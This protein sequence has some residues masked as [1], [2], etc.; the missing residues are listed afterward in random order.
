[1][2]CVMEP[3]RCTGDQHG[4]LQPARPSRLPPRFVLVNPPACVP[5]KAPALHVPFLR[6]AVAAGAAD[7]ARLLLDAGADPAL[8]TRQHGKATSA[9]H[10]AAANG[11]GGRGGAGMEFNCEPY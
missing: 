1:M 11:W 9:L 6:R 10:L 2:K 8:R 5:E 3:P 7:M 4:R